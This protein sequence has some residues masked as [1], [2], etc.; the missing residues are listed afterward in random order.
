MNGHSPKS[1]PRDIPRRPPLLPPPFVD[2]PGFRERW[3]GLLKATTMKQG[4]GYAHSYSPCIPNST[5][6]RWP[7]CSLT[8]TIML[9]DCLFR[10]ILWDW[11]EW[12]KKAIKRDNRYALMAPLS[13]RESRVRSILSMDFLLSCTCYCRA[14]FLPLGKYRVNGKGTWKGGRRSWI[15]RFYL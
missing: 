12:K 5:A 4:F 3:N 11:S 9:V 15:D 7:S 13:Y 14:H 8:N 1:F 2:A 10:V 6:V